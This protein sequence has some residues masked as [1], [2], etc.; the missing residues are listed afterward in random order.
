MFPAIATFLAAIFFF[1]GA[2][3]AQAQVATTIGGMAASFFDNIWAPFWALFFLVCF[4]GG[5]YLVVDGL[6][7]LKNIGERGESSADGIFRLLGGGVLLAIPRAAGETIATFYGGVS[8]YVASSGGSANP[9]AVQ[10][11]LENSGGI[12]CVAQNI[13]QNIVPPFVEVSF[14]IM[15]F[16]GI[17][18]IAH[19]IYEVSTSYASGRRTLPQGWFAKILLGALMANTPN[20]FFLIEETLGDANATINTYGFSTSSSML[21]YQAN[22]GS[23]I[24]Q[25]YQSLI[26]WIFEILVLFGVLSV[27]RGI[28]KIKAQADGSERGGLGSGLTHIVAGV[29]LANAK[30]TTCLVSNTMFGQGYGFCS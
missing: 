17:F 26:G 14:D 23:A 16:V 19:T 12:T 2:T 4:L 10:S 22:G 21:S 1:A 9:G 30:W 15:A 3:Q 29:L 25:E 27:W 6:I 7:R 11:C 5:L 28:M 8:N 20:L 13:A 24:L 18:M